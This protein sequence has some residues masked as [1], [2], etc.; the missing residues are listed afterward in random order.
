[1]GSKPN[2]IIN[3]EIEKF[4]I[5][6][7]YIMAGDNFKFK[8]PVRKVFF[9]NYSSFSNDYDVDITESNIIITWQVSFWLN[10]MGIENFIIDG[11]QVEGSY[12][13]EMFDLHTDELKQ[14]TM[15]NIADEE[16]KF[17]IGNDE[18]NLSLG[19]ALYVKDLDFD[20]KNK[21]CTINFQ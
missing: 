6:E 13:I 12:K 2:N 20:F 11:Q 17:V 21:T 5:N 8:Q 18:A 1:M 4:L 3:E 14:E 7:S 15:K 9:Y 19:G 16:W 10:D